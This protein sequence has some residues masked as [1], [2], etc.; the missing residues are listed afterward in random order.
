MIYA[1][2]HQL[3]YDFTSAC[4]DVSDQARL[5]VTIDAR[6]PLV[7][8]W[9]L[10]RGLRVR[11][12]CGCRAVS[13]VVFGGDRMLPD[14]A[15]LLSDALRSAAVIGRRFEGVDCGG[16]RAATVAAIQDEEPLKESER[17]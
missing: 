11:L 5:D 13:I 14:R 7:A 8:E 1:D 2:H 15:G 6:G 17:R 10:F 12:V 4:R 3:A 9:D 16:T